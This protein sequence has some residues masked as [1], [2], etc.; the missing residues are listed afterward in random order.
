[1]K[2]VLISVMLVIA[3]VAAKAEVI[4]E[5]ASAPVFANLSLNGFSR[6]MSLVNPR[7][8]SVT[9][10][11]ITFNSKT[12][13]LTVNK[14]MP[15]CGAGMMCIQVMPAPLQI[16]L[17]VVQVINNGCSTKYIATTPANIKTTVYEVIT[18]EDFSASKCDMYL[19]SVGKVTYEATG[20]SSLSKQQETATAIFHVQE[21]FI[22]AMN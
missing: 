11:A 17:T 7:F 10:A 18:I 13:Q 20:V 15:P 4:Y 1:M 5:S 8:H 14:S 22:R 2:S 21:Q 12:V 19:S 6:N 16:E 9:H 3:S